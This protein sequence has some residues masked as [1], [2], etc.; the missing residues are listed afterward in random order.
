[1]STINYTHATALQWLVETH[2]AATFIT[3]A[4]LTTGYSGHVYAVTIQSGLTSRTVAIKL[5]PP[6]SQ[7]ADTN[8]VHQRVYAT[9]VQNFA[10]AHACLQQADI[11][12]PH[13]FAYGEPSPSCPFYYQIMSLLEG[14]SIREHLAYGHGP[15]QDALHFLAGTVLGQI[16]HITRRY[17]GWVAQPIPDPL[18]WKV[19]FF[20]SLTQ[21][22]TTVL[23]Q[24]AWIQAHM[25][26]MHQLFDYYA[27][28]WSDPAVF[29]LSHGDGLQGM[30]S[31]SDNTWM[32]TGV[33][34]LEDHRFTDQ[35][36]VLAGYEL[37][38][39]FKDKVVPRTFWAGYEQYATVDPSYRLLKH[40]FQ[41]YYLLAWLPL[42]YDSTWGSTEAERQ[43]VIHT[44]ERLISARSDVGCLMKAHNKSL[45]TT[46]ST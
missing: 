40:V 10:P 33:V 39:E 44:F 27:T 23:P 17:D 22:F 45:H 16:H 29:V 41:L 11:L 38:V 20:Q 43:R 13:V 35:R 26:R 21:H 31:Y 46:R 36:F 6:E 7:L 14:V 12:V 30:A 8:A 19:A 37:A 18:P 15:N 34:D 24:N 5:T 28:V 9:R 4:D 32:F 25:E 3:A 2:L 1:M 42:C